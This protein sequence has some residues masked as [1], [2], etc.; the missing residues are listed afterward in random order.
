MVIGVL[1]HVWISKTA[2]APPSHD[3]RQASEVFMN[4]HKCNCSDLLQKLLSAPL[5]M[6]HINKLSE[7]YIIVDP[8]LLEVADDIEITII[9]KNATWKISQKPLA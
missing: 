3:R 2:P 8:D 5:K 9:G 6:P 1:V 7:N 4:E